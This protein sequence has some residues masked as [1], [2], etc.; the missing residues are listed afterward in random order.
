MNKTIET[1]NFTFALDFR[2]AVLPD[3]NTIPFTR[4]EAAILA[5]FT[6][7]PSQVLSRNQ[8][9]DAISTPGS[10]KSDRNIDLVIN[11]LRRKLSDNAKDPRFIATRYGEGYVWVFK[12]APQLKRAKDAFLIIGPILGLDSLPQEE[13]RALRFTENLKTAIGRQLDPGTRVYL[14]RNFE[15]EVLSRETSPKLWL[16]QTFFMDGAGLECI[17]QVRWLHNLRTLQI[18]RVKI[19]D[20]ANDPVDIDTLAGLIL[21]HIWKARTL[22]E[23]DNT[24]LPVAMQHD[25]DD[26]L[27]DVTAIEKAEEVIGESWKQRA[28]K[29][30]ILSHEHPEDPALKLMQAIHIHSKYIQQGHVLF[31]RGEDNRHEDE[32]RIE[33]LVLEAMP[34]AQSRPEHAIMAA[35]LLYFIDKGYR[36]AAIEIAEDAFKRSTAIAASLTSIGQLRSFSGQPDAALPCFDQAISLSKKGS[37]FHLYTLVMKCQALL[38]ANDWQA[39]G[40]TRRELFALAP[41]TSVF[42]EPLFTGPG[43]PSLRARGIVF[44]LPRAR[45]RAQLQHLGYVSARLFRLQEHRENSLRPFLTLCVR[46]FGKEVVPQ[47]VVQLAP[48]LVD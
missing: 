12:P 10:D 40:E 1:G 26:L 4:S 19:D 41:A 23:E 9:L 2:S 22:D 45:A 3:G 44:V 35:K 29:L 34:Y 33:Q 5:F 7:H 42:L 11:R 16:S 36:D 30:D 43:K 6:Q 48:D 47:E 37:K 8:I 28:A 25:D 38:A 31:H 46:R 15:P 27:E 24:P 20:S 18:R 14:D 32:N 17:L 13:E 39:L 21:S